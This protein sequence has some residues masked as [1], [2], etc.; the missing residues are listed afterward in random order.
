MCTDI[1]TEEGP[2]QK[3]NIRA[4]QKLPIPGKSEYA[5]LSWLLLHT[6]CSFKEIKTL[7][8]FSTN[9]FLLQQNEIWGEKEKIKKGHGKHWGKWK[10]M[11]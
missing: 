1:Q 5:L 4:E 3:E 7:K 10:N 6:P 11:L 2:M 8:T 9:T